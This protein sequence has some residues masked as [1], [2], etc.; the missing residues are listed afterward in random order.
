MTID[1]TY[2]LYA[3]VAFYALMVALV[4][5]GAYFILSRVIRVLGAFVPE[6]RALQEGDQFAG[7]VC[8]RAESGKA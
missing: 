3:A 2:P 5:V 4:S 7:R 8:M 1:L 6:R